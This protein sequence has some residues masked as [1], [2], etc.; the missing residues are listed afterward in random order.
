MIK[1]PVGYEQRCREI[2]SCYL[3][4]IEVYS[5]I[6]TAAVLRQRARGISVLTCA[7]SDNATVQMLSR[8]VVN[9]FTILV[10]Y[11]CMLAFNDKY[12]RYI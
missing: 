5:Y 3:T 2:N 10:C 4:R 1:F 6:S 12:R 8:H 11:V 7:N 9:R